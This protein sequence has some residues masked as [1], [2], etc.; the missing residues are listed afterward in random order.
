MKKAAIVLCLLVSFASFA[1]ATAESNFTFG[2]AFG[3][4]PVGFR[5]VHQ[6]DYARGYK[7]AFDFEGKPATGERARPV[8]TL[9]WYPAQLD[10]SAQQMLYGRYVE[11][12]ATEENF[13]GDSAQK[14][15]ALQTVL[16]QRQLKDKWEIERVQPTHAFLDAKPASG[17]FP[18]VIY[19]P[20]FSAPA[21][22]NSDLCEYLASHGYIVL[23]SPNMGPHS[24]LMTGDVQGIQAQVGDIEFLLGYL[25]NIPQADT[26]RIAVAGFS[27]GGISNVFAQ[28]QDDRITA[29]AC[30]DGTIRYRAEYLKEATYVKPGRLTVPLLFLAQRNI[31]PEDLIRWKFD[32]STSFLNDLKY[33]DFHF[34]SF[35]G[36]NHQDFSSLFIR[37]RPDEAFTEY[38]PSEI[39]ESHGWM[40]R[41]TLNFLNAYL[42]DDATAREFL[43]TPPDKNGVPRHLLA[44]QFRAALRPA[45]VVSDFAR[46]L[47]EQGFDKAIPIWQEAKKN[48]PDFKLSEQEV[49]AWGYQL[50]GA[51]KLAEAIAVFQLNVAM[52]PEGF[53][54]YD[55]LA[56]AQAAAG[57]KESAIANYRKS[58]ELNSANENAVEWL[59]KLETKTVQ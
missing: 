46:E 57:D 47:A 14:A 29:L 37:F 17:K 18:V 55:S 11:L 45:P 44:T 30:L 42:K 27:W 3:P 31:S 59:K 19:A 5:V 23:A 9:I 52:Y 7:T 16:E 15:A 6:F 10:K 41:Y 22:E 32:L 48:D 49:N 25:H 50:M 56:E 35:A 58:L 54:T 43:K 26:S 28:M 12:F 24:R 40:A 34:V 13:D 53:N 51:K 8:Q 4:H 21:F 39:S 20:S 2:V 1:F 38:T 33:S 36:M